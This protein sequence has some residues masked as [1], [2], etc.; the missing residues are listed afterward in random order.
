MRVEN[1]SFFAREH[2]KMRAAEGENARQDTKMR[3]GRVEYARPHTK[4]RAKQ[5]KCENARKTQN[6]CILNAPMKQRNARPKP[7]LKMN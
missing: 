6:C 3:V 1:F 2:T 7:K 5:I 4:M